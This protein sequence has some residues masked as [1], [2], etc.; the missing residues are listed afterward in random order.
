ME[1]IGIGILVFVAALVGTVTGFGIGTVMVPVMAAFYSLPQTLLFVGVIH[2]FGSLWKVLL[3][4]EG[5]SWKIIIAFGITA[6]AASFLGASITIK[7]P[8]A[9][10]KSILGLFLIAYAVS[11]FV[12]SNFALPKNSGTLAVGRA[13]SGFTSGIFGIGGEIRAMVLSAFNLPKAVFLATS[14]V[15]GLF[16]DASRLATY[17]GGGIRLE[18]FFLWGLL[19]FVPVSFVG[20]KIAQKIVQ[21]IPQDKFRKVVAAFLLAVGLYL[22][23]V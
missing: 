19:I 15:L 18:P 2:L 6:V 20:A 21:K 17:L 3:F 16:V 9:L 5:V 22:F 12:K 23:F 1:L 8:E 14:G 11:V 4:R 10:L 7:A 13:V